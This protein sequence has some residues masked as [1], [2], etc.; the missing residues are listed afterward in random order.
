M[1]EVGEAVDD[2]APFGIGDMI[3]EGIFLSAVEIEWALRR[4][5]AKKNLILQGARCG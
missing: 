2:L 4:L 5:R 1:T 3:D